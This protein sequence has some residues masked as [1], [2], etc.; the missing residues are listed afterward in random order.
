MPPQLSVSGL[1]IRFGGI[2]ALDGVTFDVEKG[3]IFG[4]I[5]PNGAGK[6]TVFNLI[7]R[8][9]T[10]DLG[11][12]T[13][14][15]KNLLKAAPHKVPSFGIARTFQ[16][17]IIFPGMTVRDNV[18]VGAHSWMVTNPLLSM[19]RWPTVRRDERRAREKAELL[20]DYLDLTE[21]A[22]RSPADLTFPTRKRIE[23]ARALMAEP[24][25]ILLDEPA[26][27]LTHTEVNSL[28]TLI[29]RVRDELSVT[30]LLVEHHMNLVMGISDRI[31]VLDFGRKIAEGKPAEI[32]R[33]PAVIRA[34]LGDDADEEVAS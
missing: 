13:M 16:N 20:L 18:L 4:L 23:L 26:G 6:T 9:Y 5:G 24:T 27:G 19:V 30:I 33:D 34:Y 7:S 12:I 15:G 2:Q 21:W 25:L 31:C 1:S 29:K 11:A 28:G 3:Q 14:D 22:E 10:P 32:Q 17:V 8:I